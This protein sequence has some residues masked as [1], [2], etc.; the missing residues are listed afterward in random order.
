MLLAGTATLALALSQ[1]AALAD[2]PHHD[3]H[4]DYHH[5][6]HHHGRYWGGPRVIRSNPVPDTP[7]NRERFGGPRSSGGRQTAPIGN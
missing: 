6:H 1:G 2:P 3:Y 7:R 5:H 4:H